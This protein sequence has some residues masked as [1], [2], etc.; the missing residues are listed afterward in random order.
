MPECAASAE[1]CSGAYPAHM[2][3]S[4]CKRSDVPLKE[5]IL[6]LDAAKPRTEKF[7]IQDLSAT[8]LFIEAKATEWL[9]QKVQEFQDQNTYQVRRCTLR[10]LSC[11]AR[12]QSVSERSG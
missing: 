12:C 11:P 6:S 8:R 7:V 5:F 9:T 4:F 1:R 3:W 2:T 10:Q